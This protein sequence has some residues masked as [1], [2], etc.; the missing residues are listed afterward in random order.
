[1][2]SGLRLGLPWLCMAGTRGEG[3]VEKKGVRLYGAM[4]I[5]S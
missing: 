3:G 1:M 5:T 4:L 2:H